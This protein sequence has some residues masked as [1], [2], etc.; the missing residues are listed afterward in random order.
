MNGQQLYEK[1]QLMS[2]EEREKLIITSWWDLEDIKRCIE[3]L[4]ASGRLDRRRSAV[5]ATFDDDDLWEILNEAVHSMQYP[6]SD[7][8]QT[9]I[10]DELIVKADYRYNECIT[11]E[12]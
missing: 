8:I 9:A 10:L 11:K 12:N 5:I 1:M 6:T 2:E 7:Q 3:T 4:Q